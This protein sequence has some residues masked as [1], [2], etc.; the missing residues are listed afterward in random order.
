MS[1]IAPNMVRFIMERMEQRGVRASVSVAGVPFDDGGRDYSENYNHVLVCAKCDGPALEALQET[2]AKTRRNV[3][4][5]LT[6][7]E[8]GRAVLSWPLIQ[9]GAADV[10]VWDCKTDPSGNAISSAAARLKRW[11]EVDSILDGELVRR[12]LIGDSPAWRAVLRQLIEISCFTGDDILLHGESGTGK[13]LVTQLVHT[14]DRRRNKRDLIIVDCTTL[15]PELIGSELF[16]HERGAFTGA[17]QGREGAFSLADQGSLFLDEIGELPIT[18][19]AQLLRVVQERTFKPVGGN[20]WHP[21]H[22]RLVCATHRDLPA[23][24]AAG[25]FRHDL[26]WRI[27]TH[28]VT[29]PPLR[30]RR[31]DVIPLARHFMAELLPGTPDIEISQPVQAY[32]LNH[33]WPGNIRQ[34]R[35]CLARICARH[36]GSGPITIG[37]L[38]PTE[39][40]VQTSLTAAPES[41][42]AVSA[43][44]EDTAPALDGWEACVR[45]A[46]DSGMQLKDLGRRTQDI[47]IRI[48]VDEA[49]GNLQRAAHRLGVSDRTV[50]LWRA[51]SRTDAPGLA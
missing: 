28:V 21:S 14:L 48:A 39:W 19:Q 10:V 4:V 51:Q 32:L 47:A 20:R 12:N 3:L 36:V 35:Q 15:V 22:F 29:L 7:Q 44:K 6:V 18:L 8:G 46:L 11:Q 33:A 1:D 31:E 37:D 9:H 2:C 26:Y 40:P 17:A 23:D 38:P 16:G 43:S 49:G 34:L 27:A 41:S 5:L 13:E 42:V 45:H 50:Q 24:V 30:E 25:R